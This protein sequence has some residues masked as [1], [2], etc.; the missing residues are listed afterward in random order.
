MRDDHDGTGELTEQPLEGLLA[1]EIEMVVRL[2]EEQE[3][4]VPDEACREPDELSLAPGQHGERPLPLVFPDTEVAQ[5]A[6]RPVPQA[7]ATGPLEAV[8]QALLVLQHAGQTRHVAADGRIGQA[9]TD[10]GEVPLDRGEIGPRP[11]QRGDDRDVGWLLLLRQVGDPEVARARHEAALGELETGDRAQQRRL[12]A[13]IWSDQ[14]D[15]RVAIDGPG[16][17]REDRPVAV[18]ARNACEVGDDHEVI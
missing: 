12:P 5:Q 1:R 16:E 10:R 15:P 7:R 2:V 4:R 9:L 17:V 14:A 3:I 11:E 13:A 6:R 8:E 18:S